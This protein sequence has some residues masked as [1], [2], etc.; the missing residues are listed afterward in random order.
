MRKVQ[1]PDRN[2]NQGRLFSPR[3]TS[4]KHNSKDL[5]LLRYFSPG[6]RV[7]TRYINFIKAGYILLHDG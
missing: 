5:N 7:N 6:M 4:R 2:N 3:K 1:L